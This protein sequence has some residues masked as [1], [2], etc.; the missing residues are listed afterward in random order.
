MTRWTVLLLLLGAAVSAQPRGVTFTDVT[1]A[2]GIGFVHN[3]GR[4][5]KKYL[6][7]TLGSG[8]AFFD[9]DGDGWPDL[10][11]VNGKDWTP[12]GKRCA[13]F[14]STTLTRMS[15][16]LPA[17]HLLASWASTSVRSAPVGRQT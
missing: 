3:S 15:P 13:S 11:L 16:L 5:G 14:I 7:E 9:A 6:P 1:T 12:G 8:A 17:R 4:A 2:S 10:F